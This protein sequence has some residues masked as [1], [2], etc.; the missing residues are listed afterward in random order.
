MR[1]VSPLFLF[2]LSGWG[3]AG[4]RLHPDCLDAYIAV[5]EAL[6]ADNYRGSQMALENLWRRS[7]GELAALVKRAVATPDLAAMREAFKAISE[8]VASKALPSGYL[9]AYCDLA[10]IDQGAHWVQR[11]GPLRNPY[12]GLTMLSRGRILRRGGP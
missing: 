2:L 12:L 3:W 6:A 7:E 9:L 1:L 8:L 10:F 11:D 5:Q 4:D